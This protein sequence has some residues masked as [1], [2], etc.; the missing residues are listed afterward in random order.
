M[1]DLHMNPTLS[2]CHAYHKYIMPGCPVKGTFSGSA[3]GR[4]EAK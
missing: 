2:V 3:E 4:I 1:Y